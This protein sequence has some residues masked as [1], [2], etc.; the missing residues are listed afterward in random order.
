[1]PH[2]TRAA[3]RKKVSRP[4]PT[5]LLVQR[6]P[7]S[8]HRGTGV[9]RPTLGAGR[10][11]PALLPLRRVQRSCCKRLGAPSLAAWQ[12]PRPRAATEAKV[13]HRGQGYRRYSGRGPAAAAHR[14]RV[15]GAASS[16]GRRAHADASHGMARPAIEGHGGIRQ[17]PVDSHR[18]PSISI[19]QLLGGSYSAK[20]AAR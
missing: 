3:A 5:P 11:R 20:A 14:P 12:P 10:R 4:F 6:A 8:I 9:F 1:M 16:L 13:S 15:P 7:P 19:V 2:R 17:Y 18:I